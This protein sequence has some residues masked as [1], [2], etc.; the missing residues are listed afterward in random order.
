MDKKIYLD[1]SSADV[2]FWREGDPVLL[3]LVKGKAAGVYN[4]VNDQLPDEFVERMYNC[5]FEVAGLDK[6]VWVDDA[7]NR[8][9][10]VRE[11]T[12]KKHGAKIISRRSL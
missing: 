7:I 11:K 2:N 5:C 3:P 4:I 9:I 6:Y 8:P 1:I 10:A 12:A